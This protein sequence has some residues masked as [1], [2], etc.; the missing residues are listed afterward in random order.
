[1]SMSFKYTT[2]KNEEF[3]SWNGKYITV[4]NRGAVHKVVAKTKEECAKILEDF[5][6]YISL[7]E[8]YF[9]TEGIGEPYYDDMKGKWIGESYIFLK[10]K[11]EFDFYKELYKQ[12]KEMQ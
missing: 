10:D 9:C 4:Y 8:Q 11:E 12:F 2:C 5:Y 1:M 3:D 7:H 6:D